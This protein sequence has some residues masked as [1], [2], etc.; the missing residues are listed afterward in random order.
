[1]KQ[2]R[3]RSK[4]EVKEETDLSVTDL[5][6]V[7][8]YSSPNRHPKQVINV[9]YLVEVREGEVTVADDAVDFKWFPLNKIPDELAFDHKQNIKDAIKLIK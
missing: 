6:L 4:E 7:G 9:V 5:K 8:V 3:R 1:M 2:P